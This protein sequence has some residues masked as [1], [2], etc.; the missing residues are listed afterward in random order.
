MRRISYKDLLTANTADAHPGALLPALLPP[1][2]P[3]PNPL[4]LYLSL[5]VSLSLSLPLLILAPDSRPPG[6]LS[7]W[8]CCLMT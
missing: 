1:P 8:H 4:C 2:P 5:S 7:Q 6:A 3:T